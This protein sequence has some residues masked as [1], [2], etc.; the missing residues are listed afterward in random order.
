[1]PKIN[2][3]A[4][5]IA[6]L[7]ATLALPTAGA[8]IDAASY[9]SQPIH[10]I[11]PFAPA[12]ASDFVARIMQNS[13]A[14]FLGQP[15]V[16][17]NRAGAAG[18]IGM[19]EAARAAGDGYTV[20][21]GNVGTLAVNSS[22]FPHLHL[23]PEEDFLAITEVAETPDVLIANPKFPPKTVK[24]LV[25]YVKAHPGVVN[26]ASPG[27]GSLNRLEME[28]FRRDAGLDMQ[29]VPYKGGAGPAVLDVLAGHVEVMFTTLPS[30]IEQIK[31]GNVKALAVTTK[32]RVPALPDIP[33]M[34]ELGYPTSVS[35][36]WQGLAVPKGTPRQIVDKLY[37]ASAHTLADKGVRERF[38]EGGVLPIVSQSP[39]EFAGF[40]KSEAG[41]WAQVVKDTGATAE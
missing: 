20:F 28:V 10:L 22:L 1:V 25:D 8:A 38:S 9:P 16:I 30:A 19:A 31:S 36:S 33:T 26:F 14:E 4:V 35:S 6:T 24:E 12:G 40:I 13:M 27:S 37:Q 3:R 15:I 21:L 7:F 32:Q 2:R 23:K 34:A 41:K 29:H 17:D 39:E 18:N 11:V 5:I